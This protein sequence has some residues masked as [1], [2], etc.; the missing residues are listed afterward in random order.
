MTDKTEN[1]PAT[2]QLANTLRREW[3]AIQMAIGSSEATR[4][5]ISASLSDDGPL[6][7]E[8]EVSIVVF[9][10]LARNEWN[11]GS[12][13]DWTLLIDGPADPQ[14]RSIAHFIPTRLKEEG[15]RCPATAG[16]FG[17]MAFSH[18]IIHQIGGEKDT[19]R[20]LTQRILLLLESQPL[21][22]REAYDRVVT[23]V[24][25]RYLEDD[26]SFLISSGKT[27]T[28]KI[29]RF[30]LNDIV[31]Y[32]RTMAVDYAHKRYER[33]G[34]GWA[35]RNIKL[36]MSRKVIFVC[37]L[38]TC[39]SCHLNPSPAIQDVLDGKVD[40]Q[41]SLVNHLV[42]YVRMTPLDILAEGLQLYATDATAK[43]VFDAYNDFLKRLNCPETRA[44]LDK[45][46]S[47]QADKDKTFNEL[48]EISREFQ[49]GLTCFF[50]DED[51]QLA[52]LIQKYGVF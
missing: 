43:R 20:N 11:E 14:H 4:K 18:D 35:L 41:S 19:N 40:S 24:L 30:L 42:R 10:S 1:L 44:H 34:K 7:P 48:C 38:L 39:F 45:L 32:W 49:K 52:E 29:P 22:S 37:G 16:V 23:S 47:S 21:V 36:R 26:I 9:G 51:K 13:I 5:R 25:G 8:A 15:L 17:S 12:D 50:F 3:P 2:T 6:V 27:K 28:Y 46:D 31:R 33:A